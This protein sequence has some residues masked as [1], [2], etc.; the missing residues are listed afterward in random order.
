MCLW[1]TKTLIITHRDSLRVQWINSLYNMSGMSSKEV[2]EITSS[3][4]LYNIAMGIIDLKYDVYL[5][6]HATFRAGMKRIGSM[7]LAQNITKNLGIGLKIIDEA[8]LEF[9]DTI[10]M[11]CVFNVCR[12]I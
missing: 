12:N 3:E 8:H 10:L 7:T 6:T 9:R 2:H 4:E 1:K 11:D 5:L